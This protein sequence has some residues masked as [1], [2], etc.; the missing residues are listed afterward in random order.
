MSFDVKDFTLGTAVKIKSTTDGAD[1]VP[2]HIVDSS[3]LPTG[4]ATEV[5]LADVKTAVEALSAL[6][7]G[8]ELPVT[9]ADAG[10]LLTALGATDFATQTTL[11]AVLAKIIAAPATEA[12]QDTANT[13]LAS[14][15]AKIIAAPSTEAKQDTAN[16]LL[17]RSVAAEY[18]TV[19]ASQTAQTLG[20]TGAAGDYLSHVVCF[21][22]TATPGVVTIL[23]NA[24]V[25]GTFPGGASSVGTL[26]PFTIPVGMISSSGAWKITT[27]ADITAVGVGDF[28]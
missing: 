10:T 13:S 21:P 27:G 15:L 24:T 7:A 11:A 9:D 17:S 28:T 8:G 6:I 16:T 14:I 20:A 22:Q 18:E 26:R 25:I 19:A 2:H 3:A 1:Q 5:T 23:D 4:A 12:K